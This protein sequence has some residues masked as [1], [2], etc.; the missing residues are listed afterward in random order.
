[1]NAEE[2][3][4]AGIESARAGDMK[5]ATSLLVESLKLNPNS[6]QAWLWLGNCLISF[7]EREYCYKRALAIN[8]GSA[9]AKPTA[10]PVDCTHLA[11]H[12]S[13][14]SKNHPQVEPAPPQ[15]ESNPVSPPLPDNPRSEGKEL[16]QALRLPDWIHP[17]SH[18][19]WR[20]S[21]LILS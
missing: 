1:M 6:E 3:L 15:A 16:H 17:G 13:R 5:K 9:E 14:P 21:L 7:K 10:W 20:D 12:N 8:P 11:Y 18:N 4:R 19:L 2:L